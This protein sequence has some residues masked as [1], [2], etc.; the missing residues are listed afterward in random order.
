MFENLFVYFVTFVLKKE[1]NLRLYLIFSLAI[2]NVNIFAQDIRYDTVKLFYPIDKTELEASHQKKLD[3][4]L[5]MLNRSKKVKISITGYAD[6][7]GTNPHNVDLSVE[8]ANKV[9]KYLATKG[10][11]TT[12]VSE[13]GGR[14]ALSGITK[15]KKDKGV[16]EHRRVDVV[17]GWLVGKK[18]VP[19]VLKPK[20]QEPVKEAQADNKVAVK[21]STVAVS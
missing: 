1:I 8:R 21:L 5:L 12:R 4:I 7:L 6:F 20:A 15:N 13:C 2:I 16:P 18:P 10:F 11:D 17:V 19:K 14:G 9:K 3:S